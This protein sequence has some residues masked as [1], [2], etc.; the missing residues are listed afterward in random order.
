M[1]PSVSVIIL[2]YN[3]EK[4]IGICA[5]SLFG[6]TLKDVEYIFVDDCSPDRSMDI[7]FKIL[8]EE[9]PERKSQ[10]RVL[11][12]EKNYGQAYCRRRGVEASVGKYTIHC[13]SDDWQELHMLERMYLEARAYDADAVV[14]AWYR[15]DTPVSTRYNHV[16][17]NIRDLI[18]NDMVAVGELQ[19][20]WRYMVKR[21]VYSR[22][23]EFPIFNQGEDHAL[24]VQLIWKSKDVYCV[25]EPLY[26]WR[27]N[28]G[29]VTRDP[30]EKGVMSR[31]QGDC[32]NDR[33]IETFLA[34]EGVLDRFTYQLTAHKLLCMFDLRPLLRKGEAIDMWRNEFPEI[35]GKV[36][37]NKHIKFAHKVEYL[38]VRYLP[39]SVIKQVYR[40][41]KNSQ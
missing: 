2:V 25:N 5:R 28:M 39:A 22:G 26:H 10:V 35:K 41:R 24:M 30:S 37:S 40:W 33:L 31:F 18:L 23:I 4:Y 1:T 21:E 29:S 12:N 14:C 6:Q 20:L 15:D 7:L 27:T 9:F 8:E 11:R 38:M 3:V 19:S 16:G 17:E 34:K 32:A 36:L 13:D